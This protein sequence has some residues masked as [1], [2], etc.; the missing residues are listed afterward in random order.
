MNFCSKLFETARQINIHR[1]VFTTCVPE[2]GGKN[3]AVDLQIEQLIAEELFAHF[4]VD[5]I[6]VKFQSSKA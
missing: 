2:S 5:F 6:L 4:G 3:V 1:A